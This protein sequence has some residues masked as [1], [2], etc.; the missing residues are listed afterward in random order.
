MIQ[1]GDDD[2]SRT[3]QV[4]EGRIIADDDDLDTTGL[5]QIKDKFAVALAA[6]ARQA[7]QILDL[8][9]GGVQ[10]AIMLNRPVTLPNGNRAKRHVVVAR[11]GAAYV[12]KIVQATGL[13]YAEIMVAHE[14]TPAY[15]TYL[16]SS[17]DRLIYST[18]IPDTVMVIRD[19][20]MVAG[21]KFEVT[22]DLDMVLAQNLQHAEDR[23]KDLVAQAEQFVR[24]DLAQRKRIEELEAAIN[25]TDDEALKE[26]VGL[27]R[28][29]YCRHCGH[30]NCADYYDECS[31]SDDDD[32]DDT[33]TL[34]GMIAADARK[35]SN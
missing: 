5:E 9:I 3:I 4:A 22:R 30:E 1:A 6:Q 27:G 16:Q 15:R 12:D 24:T 25:G 10:I 28:V 33:T 26:S 14:E 8:E 7:G 18:L 13:K 32:D 29:Y 19:E 34:D 2:V 17:E 31:G 11:G 35:G 23:A 20:I 21:K